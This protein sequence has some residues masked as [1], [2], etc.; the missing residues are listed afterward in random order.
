MHMR[1]GKLDPG[2]PQFYECVNFDRETRR[3]TK[4]EDRP[5]V[6]RDYP[7]YGQRQLAPNIALPH[8]CSFR[9]DIGQEVEPEPDWQAIELSRK[10]AL[11]K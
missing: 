1:G 3:C 10:E 7:Y 9:A 6:C 8:W 11:P 2:Y 4:Y 5:P